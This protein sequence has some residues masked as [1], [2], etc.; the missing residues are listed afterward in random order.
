MCAARTSSKLK[1]FAQMHRLVVKISTLLALALGCNVL[2]F[3]RRCV[4]NAAS[5]EPLV[6]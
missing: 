4:N 5:A 2:A 6:A 1:V 3:R